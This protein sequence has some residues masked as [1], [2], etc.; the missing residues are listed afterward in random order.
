MSPLRGVFRSIGFFRKKSTSPVAAGCFQVFF[1][2]SYLAK[3]AKLW[4]IFG[5]YIFMVGKIHTVQTFS[6]GSIGQVSFCGAKKHKGNCQ[7]QY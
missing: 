7:I 5:E 3:H 1:F 6:S 2:K 4:K